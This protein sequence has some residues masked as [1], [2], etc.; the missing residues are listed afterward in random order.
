MV[1]RANQRKA[2]M[3]HGVSSIIE[4]P[5][6]IVEYQAVSAQ[7]LQEKIAQMSSAEIHVASSY[8]QAKEQLKHHRHDY[9]VA[10]SDL[11]LPDAPNAE[12]IDLLEKAGV[13]SIALTGTFAKETRASLSKTGLVDYVLKDS[14]RSYDYV[15]S[16]VERLHRNQFVKALVVEDSKSALFMLQESME[17]L[18]FQVFTATNG[19]EA[20][21]VFDA[22]PDI[23][24]L[25]TDH[26]M[27]EMDGFELTVNI[28]ERLGKEQ[29]AIIGLSASTNT[30]LGA[31]FIKNGAN[32]FLLKPYS[33]DELLC[34]VNMNIAALEHLDHITEL[35][36]KDFLTKLFNR[37]YF[38]THG[39]DIFAQSEPQHNAL[40]IVMS[41]IDHFKKVNDTYG[42]DCGDAVLIHVANLFSGYF[43]EHLVARLGGEEFAVIIEGVSQEELRH[44][45]E[46]FRREVENGEVN[47]MGHC[48]KVTISIGASPALQNSLDKSLKLADEMLYQAKDAGRNQ[49]CLV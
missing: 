24:L 29:L 7:I 39:E 32:D 37:R 41:D 20:L 15:V 28:R 34:R 11:N 21:A 43:K 25:L 3:S 38:F 5:I 4:R 46:A 30:D 12:I 8:Q 48:I 18:N 19:K 42:H 14:I 23:R 49:V 22:H 47:T 1:V 27:P 26:E 17:L 13:R 9:L 31:M 16:L 40:S 33:F 10:I 6:L 45:L 35:A 44:Y 2:L 36:N